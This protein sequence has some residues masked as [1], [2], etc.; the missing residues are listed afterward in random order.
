MDLWAAGVWLTCDDNVVFVPQFRR[1]VLDTAAWLR[2]GGGSPLPFAGLP[3]EATHRRLMLCARAD[4]ETEADYELRSQ[5]EAL[6]WGPAIDNV[7]THLFRNVDRLVITC[8]FWCEEHLLNDPRRAHQVY[9][10]EIPTHEFVS[11][12]EDLAA[13][14]DDA[15]ATTVRDRLGREA[16][17][18]GTTQNVEVG[19]RVSPIHE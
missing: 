18:V 12:L 7:T 8:E 13:V 17:A 1:D 19:F 2:S 16:S 11:I 15:P 9:T 5:F 3:P 4:D 6:R 10:V 14:L